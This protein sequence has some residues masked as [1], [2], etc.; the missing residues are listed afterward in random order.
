MNYALLYW[1]RFWCFFFNIT[2]PHS[3]KCPHKGLIYNCNLSKKWSVFFFSLSSL[4]LF[5]IYSPIL[6]LVYLLTPFEFHFIHVSTCRTVTTSNLNLNSAFFFNLWL[7]MASAFH[8][9]NLQTLEDFQKLTC[10]YK[11]SKVECLERLC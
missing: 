2:L 9:W 3:P 7:V 4:T 6:F 11:N 10:F 8:L 5:F 1:E